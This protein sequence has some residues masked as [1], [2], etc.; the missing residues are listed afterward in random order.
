MRLL[1]IMGAIAALLISFLMIM[2]GPLKNERGITEEV[3]LKKV[4]SLKVGDN[5][6][7]VKHFE[8]DF[9]VEKEE[10]IINIIWKSKIDDYNYQSSGAEIKHDGRHIQSIPLWGESHVKG[11]PK[12]LKILP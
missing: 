4:D 3:F 5:L 10:F 8:R 2:K 6:S 1:V 12:D 9:L 11:R 7:K